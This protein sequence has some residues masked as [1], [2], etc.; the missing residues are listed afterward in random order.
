MPANL[1]KHLASLLPFLAGRLGA[2][3]LEGPEVDAGDEDW[4]LTSAEALNVPLD[5]R[6]ARGRAEASAPLAEQRAEMVVA[7]AAL[8]GICTPETRDWIAMRMLASPDPA[9]HSLARGLKRMWQAAETGRR[10]AAERNLQIACLIHAELLTLRD[11]GASGHDIRGRAAEIVRDR[12]LAANPETRPALRK[13]L[14]EIYRENEPRVL[15]IW[16][17]MEALL[18]AR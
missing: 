14:L 8:L 2:R 11:S 7:T 17:E 10:G 18:L 9:M 16:P 15:E 6:H 4:A 5:P 12:L 3:W 13:R 1:R